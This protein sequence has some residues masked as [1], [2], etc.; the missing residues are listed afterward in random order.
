ME[1]WELVQAAINAAELGADGREAHRIS[2]SVLEKPERVS[3]EID[4]LDDLVAEA[5][6]RRE[7]R[8]LG[9]S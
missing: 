7:R 9:R 1:R 8:K 2:M 6:E 5:D 3:D 4:A